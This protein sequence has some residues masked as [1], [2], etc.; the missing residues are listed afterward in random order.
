MGDDILQDGVIEDLL[1]NMEYDEL[2]AQNKEIISDEE[3]SIEELDSDII[4][5]DIFVPDTEDKSVFATD[6]HQNVEV[7]DDILKGYPNIGKS[8]DKYRLKPAIF[9]MAGFIVLVILFSSFFYFKIIKINGHG[10][11]KEKTR[12]SFDGKIIEKINIIESELE[13]SYVVNNKSGHIFV[14]NGVVKNNSLKSIS[15]ISVRGKLYNLEGLELS[16]EDAFA[17]NIINKTDLAN[18]DLNKLKDILLNN[19]YGKTRLN[20]KIEPGG[21]TPFM[22]VFGNLPL[23]LDDYSV[24]ITG[25]EVAP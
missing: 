16:S 2:Q 8:S 7:V 25:V 23:G 6:L 1:H 19:P 24:E 4:K 18:N 20:Y 10:I 5:A 15:L 11:S 9:F 17:G 21:K 3:S 12:E 14:I 22:L 13:H